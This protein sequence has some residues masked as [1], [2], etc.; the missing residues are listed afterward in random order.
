M[1]ERAKAIVKGRVVDI[2]REN[3]RTPDSGNKPKMRKRET[4]AEG[5]G[6][7]G[8]NIFP[9]GAKDT[10]VADIVMVYFTDNNREKLCESMFSRFLSNFVTG[11][12]W[13]FSLSN[14]TVYASE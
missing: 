10:G 12:S 7:I 2:E 13:V 14:T 11:D 5:E 4:A 1:K 9:M 8:R 6:G 3:G